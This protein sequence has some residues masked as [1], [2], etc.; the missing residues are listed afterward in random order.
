MLLSMVALVAM[1]D[2]PLTPS[3]K[4]VVDYA[5]N[6][7]SAE[8]PLA[9]GTALIGLR[10]TSP[11]SRG[12]ALVLGFPA[13]GERGSA[14]YEGELVFDGAGAPVEVVVTSYTLPNRPMRVSTLALSTENLTRLRAAKSIRVRV[15]E[16]RTI[17]VQPGDLRAAVGALY[18]CN[19]DLLVTMGADAKLLAEAVV[20]PEPSAENLQFF[21]QRYYPRAALLAR[22]SGRNMVF[23]E[24]DT[25][26]KPTSCR[27]IHSAGRADLDKAA[28]EGAMRGR[29]TPARNAAGEAV[30]S[31]YA[32]NVAWQAG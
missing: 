16:N 31:W 22:A 10:P 13:N 6:M 7:C 21:G 27:V 17:T 12:A 24:I 20:R 29:Y 28:C 26:G 18:T 14:R 15:S 3:G 5:E 30:R 32:Q 23:V 11:S 25:A 4:W 19:D 1:Q 9:G 8:R 2:A